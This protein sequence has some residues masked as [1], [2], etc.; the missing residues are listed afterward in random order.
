MA[1]ASQVSAGNQPSRGRTAD[2]LVTPRSRSLARLVGR[3][4]VWGMI[5]GNAAPFYSTSVSGPTH[6]CPSARHDGCPFQR[7]SSTARNDGLTPAV[8]LPDSRAFCP[9]RHHAPN[10]RRRT[11]VYGR[12]NRREA[13]LWAA[14]QCPGHAD[15]R[16]HAHLP[17]RQRLHAHLPPTMCRRL[18]SA[19]S[20]SWPSRSIISAAARRDKQ[21]LSSSNVNQ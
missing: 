19:P 20:S 12:R 5:A 16:F 6:V 17:F 4:L 10:G 1:G 7:H 2:A 21:Q 18:S 11:P 14:R 3:W 15:Q 8:C 13:P 9:S